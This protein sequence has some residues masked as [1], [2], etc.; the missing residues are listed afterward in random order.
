MS[1]AFI[2]FFCLCLSLTSSFICGSP[3][4][5]F[6][7]ESGS[8]TGTI[9]ETMDASGYTYL[10]LDTGKE[11]IW[12]AIPETEVQQGAK[13]TFLDGMTMQNFQ[14]KTLNKTFPTIIF[15]SGLE[16]KNMKSPHGT[17]AKKEPAGSSFAD[18]VKSESVKPQASSAQQPATGGSAGAIVPFVEL[19]VEKAAGDNSYSVAELYNQS[20]ELD[21][22]QVRIRGKVVKFSPNIMGKNWVHIQD[23]SGDP[24]KNTHDLVITTTGQVASD[25]IITF[26]GIVTANK[27][28]G[29]GYKYDVLIEQA[30]I[31][32]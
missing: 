21:G 11:K 2:L 23:G 28:F 16:G 7:Q 6:A 12:I 1:R 29:F 4:S 18:A 20:K 19:K 10:H 9:L 30:E 8:R 26:E 15:S 14:S 3:N 17:S 22:K 32:K 25:D 31:M 27:D 24:M 5:V 13:I